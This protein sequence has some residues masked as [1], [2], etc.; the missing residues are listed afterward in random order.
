M[1]SSDTASSSCCQKSSWRKGGSPLTANSSIRFPSSLGFNF[2]HVPHNLSTLQSDQ[3]EGS[4][5]PERPN[6]SSP[7][8]GIVGSQ[9]QVFR[10]CCESLT[11]NNG[12]LCNGSF[13]GSLTVGQAQGFRSCGCLQALC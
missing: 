5:Y 11:F 2:F 9:F 3:A 7:K 12:E 1:P 8:S 6:C 4:G 13:R 10:S